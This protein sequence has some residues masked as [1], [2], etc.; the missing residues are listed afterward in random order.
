MVYNFIVI[1]IPKMLGHAPTVA[2]IV[3]KVVGTLAFLDHQWI[4]A[5]YYKHLYIP[6]PSPSLFNV[7]YQI[8]HQSKIITETQH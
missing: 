1:S 5:N 6:P 4:Y 8:T 2:K 7:V 3:S